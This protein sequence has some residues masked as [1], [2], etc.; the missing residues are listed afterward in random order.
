MD[1][2]PL[3]VAIIMGAAGTAQVVV[4]KLWEAR[5]AVKARRAKQV[6][7]RRA[8]NALIKKNEID[9]QDLSM[10]RLLA[11]NDSLQRQTV[12]LEEANRALRQELA[13]CELNCEKRIDQ[14]TT[15]WQ[16]RLTNCEERRKRSDGSN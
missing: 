11:H 16:Q 13:E 6:E 7:E 10:Q 5:E 9:A 14:L 12:Q 2:G 3:Y 1:A 4:T 8:D 15:I